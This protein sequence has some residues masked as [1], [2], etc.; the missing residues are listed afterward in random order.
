MIYSLVVYDNDLNVTDVISFSAVTSAEENYSAQT[1]DSV[2][3]YGFTIS[4][5]IITQSPEISLDVIL[6]SYSIFS[7]SLLL[8]WNGSEFVTSNFTSGASTEDLHL[9]MKKKLIDIVKKRQLFT[10][11][12]SKKDSNLADYTQKAE[13]LQQSLIAKFPNCVITGLGFSDRANS[14]SAVFAKLNIKQIRVAVTEKFNVDPS[15]VKWVQ[16][17]TVASTVGAT[18]TG[19][20]KGDSADGSGKDGKIAGSDVA[21]SLKQSS[22]VAKKFE[23]GNEL[24]RNK[25]RTQQLNDQA[26]LNDVI[27]RARAANIDIINEAAPIQQMID[28]YGDNVGSIR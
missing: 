23:D 24:Y 4:D 19:G 10:L 14:A 21:P 11:I 16:K 22:G 6:S 2:V 18:S 20:T 7:D 9:E 1:T 26:Q 5:H 15:T 28:S 27:R 13:D 17:K 25:I 3:E 12:V 8:E